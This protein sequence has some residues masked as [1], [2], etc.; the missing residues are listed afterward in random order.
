LF[1]APVAQEDHA[2]RAILAALELQQ[3]LRTHPTLHAS[4][5]GACLPSAWGCARGR[6]SLVTL[7]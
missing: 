1:G 6:W 5:P 4:V 2:R 3:R 7:A